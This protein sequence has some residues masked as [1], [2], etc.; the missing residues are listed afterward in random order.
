MLTND[1][2]LEPMYYGCV[3]CQTTREKSVA[4]ALE[5]QHTGVKA[6]ALTQMKHKSEQGRKRT[7]EHILMPGYVFFQSTTDIPTYDSIRVHYMIKL[8]KYV[9]GSWQLKGRDEEFARFAFENQGVIGVSQARK[10]GD[11]VTIISGPLKEMSGNILKIDRHNR[12]GQVEFRFDERVW[13]VWLPF[14][15]VDG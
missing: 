5:E 9:D 10:I 13:K 3:F 4:K 12:N 7:V 11:R 1:T 8:L 14:E 2:L 6:I 15:L